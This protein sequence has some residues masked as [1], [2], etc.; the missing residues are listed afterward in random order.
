MG[1]PPSPLTALEV[2]VR[3]RGTTL[4]HRQLVRIHG[5]AHRAPGLAPFESGR[6]EDLVETLRFGLVLDPV[7]TG[8]DKRSHARVDM[9]T[10]QDRRGSA[11]VLNAGVRARAQ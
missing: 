8:H 10:L 11:Q 9:P 1:T 4:S 6:G 7:R 2:A 3:G 5:Q